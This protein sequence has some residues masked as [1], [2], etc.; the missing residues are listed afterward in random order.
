MLYCC[1]V[2]L[3]VDFFARQLLSHLIYHPGPRIS[4]NRRL[5]I[6]LALKMFFYLYPQRKQ[7][8]TTVMLTHVIPGCIFEDASNHQSRILLKGRITTLKN[9]V[10]KNF[11]LKMTAKKQWQK[12]CIEQKQKQKNCTEHPIAITHSMQGLPSGR[13]SCYLGTTSLII[14]LFTLLFTITVIIIIIAFSIHHIYSLGD[15]NGCWLLCFTVLF[16]IITII[17]SSSSLHFQSTIFRW[18]FKIC[19]SHTDC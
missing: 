17:I 12:Q 9:V 15:A 2:I 8:L 14:V 11:F 19:A 3:C 5:A 7:I 4:V 16:I 18:C 1:I 10:W 6:N 13:A